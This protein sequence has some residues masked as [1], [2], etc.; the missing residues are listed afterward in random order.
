MS[1]G[2][3]QRDVAARAKR[4]RNGETSHG[5]PRQSERMNDQVNS[6]RRPTSAPNPPEALNFTPSAS[7]RQP[8]APYSSSGR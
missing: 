8:S 4:R 3:G 1:G 6:R 5:S 7:S 2:I